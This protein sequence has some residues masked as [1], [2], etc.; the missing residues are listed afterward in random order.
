[1]TKKEIKNRSIF[2]LFSRRSLIIENNDIINQTSDKIPRKKS[3]N[4]LNDSSQ[5]SLLT[6][7]CYKKI[8]TT[9]IHKTIPIVQEK[10]QEINIDVLYAYNPFQLEVGK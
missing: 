10:T 8:C 9:C 5:I 2:H 6:K 4:K 1:M 7:Y 3:D